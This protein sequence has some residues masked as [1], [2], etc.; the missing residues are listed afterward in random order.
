M[1]GAICQGD[2][3]MRAF[4]LAVV[5][6]AILAAGTAFFLEGIQETTEVANATSST[7]VTPN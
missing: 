3:I 4:L 5:A 2:E 1:P 7:R 6:S